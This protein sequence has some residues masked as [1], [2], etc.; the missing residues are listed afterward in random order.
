MFGGGC[1]ERGEQTSLARVEM[2]LLLLLYLPSAPVLAPDEIRK[3]GQ[4]RAKKGG[5][6][7]RTWAEVSCGCWD[8][9][10]SIPSSD[11]LAPLLLRRPWP[12]L[13]VWSE[14]PS[15][16]EPGEAQYLSWQHPPH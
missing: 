1:A 11:H 12:Q 15:T 13:H 7:K 8:A 3:V 9:S 16:T 10:S 6:G 2:P 5:C 14:L 4:R